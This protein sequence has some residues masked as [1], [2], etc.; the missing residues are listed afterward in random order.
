MI[1]DI[2]KVGGTFSTVQAA[3]D[4]ASPG[5]ILQIEDDGDYNES[6]TVSKDN[7]T[8]RAAEGF[9]PSIY[10]YT[11][12][13]SIDAAV[14]TF[15][16]Y[17]HADSLL[18]LRTLSSSSATVSFGGATALTAH[19]L[20]FI[21]S[22]SQHCF[23]A[24]T[25]STGRLALSYITF[26]GTPLWGSMTYVDMWGCSGSVTTIASYSLLGGYIR[27]CQFICADTILYR[28][29]YSSLFDTL[30]MSANYLLCT[31]TGHE[32]MIDSDSEGLL[33]E[34]NTVEN[35]SAGNLTIFANMYNRTG[36][37]YFTNNI[38]KGFSIGIIGSKVGAR[39]DYNCIDCDTN[40]A[41]KVTAGT[42]DINVDPVLTG[43][44]INGSSPCADVGSDGVVYG[45]D[46]L[47]TPRPQEG[48]WDIGC[49]EYSVL[50]ISSAVLA[51]KTLTVTMNMA[52][53]DGSFAVPSAWALAVEDALSDAIAVDTLATDGAVAV[54]GLDVYPT[55][56]GLYE[57]TAPLDL[58]NND[59]DVITEGNAKKLFVV[60]ITEARPDPAGFL[61]AMTGATGR[62][63]ARLI[64][65][66]TTVLT[67]ILSPTDVVAEVESTL[68]FESDGF[69]Q[70]GSELV[71]YSSKTATTL[72]GL[73]REPYVFENLP[74]GTEVRDANRMWSQRDRAWSECGF[75]S[76]PD[77][78]ID[79][80]A[81]DNGFARP[82]AEM[83]TDQMRS[84]ARTLYYLDRNPWWS[85]F[86]VLRWMFQWSSKTGTSAIAYS[87]GGGLPVCWLDIPTADLPVADLSNRWLYVNGV[88]CRIVTAYDSITPDT[89]TLLMD[90]TNGPY[91]QAFDLDDG[92][93]EIAWELVAF[94]IEEAKWGPP[95]T[96]RRKPGYLK[97]SIFSGQSDMPSTYL[98]VSGLAIPQGR[99]ERGI[100]MIDNTQSGVDRNSFYLVQPYKKVTEAVIN[101]VVAA[102]VKVEVV[103]RMNPS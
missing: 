1:L 99:L 89:T 66:P 86:R 100:T 10:Y 18:R 2:K 11:P 17:G 101:D 38:I 103:S 80:L 68:N 36:T 73:T 13:I 59:G 102:G 75:A 71:A 52:P 81:A 19:H 39:G 82:I 74:I 8:I 4:F 15:A 55:P 95:G 53:Y 94:Q 16:I 70:I 23:T 42:H 64:G 31:A 41:D 67:S 27:T 43:F 40:Y 92:E 58:E 14:A 32:V 79:C 30:E 37:G 60:P 5:D 93:T 25:P 61:Q 26:R 20:D 50:K 28:Q 49:F 21:T 3:H 46:I 76:C 72:N 9:S 65:T 51:G 7:L 98:V 48:G 90:V 77:A 47:G 88:L 34:S 44:R 6:V 87:L 83:T 45:F 63:L 97:I 91:W 84:Y 24:A 22:T 29:S 69:A 54:I 12:T 62:R 78:F 56:G 57:V 35:T 85:V 33:F 96:G